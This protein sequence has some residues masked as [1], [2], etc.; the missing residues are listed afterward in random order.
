ML[1]AIQHWYNIKRIFQNKYFLSKCENEIM[2]SVLNIIG[3][4]KDYKKSMLN[5]ASY[6]IYL[7]GEMR[8]NWAKCSKSQEKW[9]KT[10]KV[11][12]YEEL[13]VAVRILFNLHS[14][15][16]FHRGDDNQTGKRE[17]FRLNYA[18]LYE[19]SKLWNKIPQGL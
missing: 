3:E 14:E 17:I 11:R 19:I 13:W 6:H 9:G 15:Q 2:T 4:V 12:G 8:R 10:S 18:P 16:Y 7:W 1:K 5:L